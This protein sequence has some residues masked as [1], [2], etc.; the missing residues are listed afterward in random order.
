MTDIP[1][2]SS[3]AHEL[4]KTVSSSIL[5][6]SMRR[7][8]LGTWMD[9]V[10]PLKLSWRVSGRVRTLQFGIKTGM[11][12]S[13][14]SIYTFAETFEEGDVMVIAAQGTRGWLLGE[15][16]ASF[17]IN[18]GVAGIVTDG[19]IRDR[20]ELLELPLPVFTKGSTARPF[21]GEVEVVAVDVPVECGGA[22]VRP[23]DLIIGDFDGVAV[24]PNAGVEALIAEARDLIQIEH[25]QGLAISQRRTLKEIRAIA[26]RKQ[27]RIGPEFDRALRQA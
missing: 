7:L 3:T 11:K 5:T 2:I 17:C 4:Y 8:G 23:G 9:E 14:H 19:R 20:L 25:E 16:I 10:E 1:K 18:C 6:D 13:S 26:D 22:Y 21:I 12:Y 15:N 24:A 27:G